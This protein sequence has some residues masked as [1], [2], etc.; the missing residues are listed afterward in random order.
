[1]R[2]G[3]CWAPPYRSWKFGISGN[4][5]STHDWTKSTRKNERSMDNCKQLNSKVRLPLATISAV[6]TEMTDFYFL[7]PSRLMLS[8][9]KLANNFTNHFGIVCYVHLPTLKKKAIEPHDFTTRPALSINSLAYII[10]ESSRTFDISRIPVDVNS[11]LR[12]WCCCGCGRRKVKQTNLSVRIGIWLWNISRL[13]WALLVAGSLHNRRAFH[14][15]IS[16][17]PIWTSAQV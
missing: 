13:L 6:S 17:R 5:S 9:F 12:I 8:V 11:T 3:T 1:M 15:A 16:R 7:K 4:G 10:S 14:T 2:L